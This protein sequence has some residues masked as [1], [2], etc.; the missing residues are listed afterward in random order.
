M[1]LEFDGTNYGI[2]IGYAGFVCYTPVFETFIEI[3]L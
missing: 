2:E 3:F 1:A